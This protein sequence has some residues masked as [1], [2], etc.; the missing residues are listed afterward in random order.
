MAGGAGGTTSNRTGAAPG[1]GGAGGSNNGNGGAGGNGQVVITV[2]SSVL[3]VELT[4]FSA[5]TRDDE[6][7]LNWTT[8][9]E[10]Q[11]DFFQI[12]HSRDGVRFQP[13][14]KVKGAGTTTETVEYHF[15]HR[16]AAAGA[17]YYRLK[18]VDIDGAFEY[19]DIVVAELRTH[20][21]GV[22]VYPNPTLDK[23]VIRLD[24]RPERISFSLFTLSG[25][26]LAVTPGAGDTMW[27]IDLSGIPSGVYVLRVNMDGQ[28]LVKRIV[29]R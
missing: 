18:Q 23:A 3:P 9:S 16:Q 10:L 29:K 1:G 13:V 28:T 26:Q 12:E 2:Q 19:S 25:K 4:R 11:N 8:A 21:G 24:T 20:G 6:V 7:E 27:E 5:D 22:E 14:G 17:N 15:L